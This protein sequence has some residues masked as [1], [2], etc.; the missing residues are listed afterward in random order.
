M[1]MK[2]LFFFVA[3]LALVGASC[4]KDRFDVDHL[5][6]VNAE[7]EM[8]LPIGSTSFTVMKL[9]Q[10]LEIDSLINC[11]E[12]GNL[13]FA[14]HYEDF[15]VLNGEELLRFKDAEY[16]AHVTF[17]NPYP[18]TLPQTF[19]TMFKFEQN[20]V[21]ES[22][23]IHV[24]KAEMK[25]GH[26]DIDLGT[27]V[28]LLQ[29][30]VL[31]SS[32]IKDEMGQDMVLDFDLTSSEIQFDL[33]GLHYV[34]ETE[35]ALNLQYEVYVKFQSTPDSELYFDMKVVGSDLAIK[36]MMGY[37]DPYESRSCID[38]M[39]NLF[40]GSVSGALEVFGARMKI[41]ER[42]TFNLEARLDVDTAW[43]ITD[44]Q[45]PS[46]IF[47]PEPLVLDIPSQNDFGQ[48]FDNTLD[49]KIS[50]N[51]TSIYASNTFIVN[52]SGM[53]DMVS[54][55]DDCVIDV[56]FDTEIPFEFKV[57][58]VC[59]SDTTRL[60]LF[61]INQPDQ[62]EKLTLE[63]TFVSTIPIN[64]NAQFYSCDSVTGQ[65]ID[66][67]L[68]EDRLIKA[69]F[70]GQPA[71]TE[72]TLEITSEKIEPFLRSEWLISRYELDTEDQS[73]VLKAQQGVE[74]S[75]KA[76]VKYNGIVEF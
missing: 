51:E 73:A 68:A 32:D 4:K 1:K 21:F 24:L 35:N 57:D 50:A 15:G 34:T 18:F 30:V 33:D 48:V 76:R 41:F 65:I 52:P 46:S 64:M 8:L 12:D 63:L 54:V 28:G 47:G 29:R 62:I 22:D 43:I 20:I 55:A 25:S 38:T 53:T 5:Q 27:N 36:S 37:V 42:N 74:V 40:P 70:D 31:R 19:D 44:G 7:G 75:L 61:E 2:R 6:G 66:T 69:S 67:L 39:F 58:D 45:E 14:F 23:H 16:S 17:E 26:F 59:Y 3:L 49:G 71:T 11:T 9:M 13:S 72:V 56:M 10:Q 60:E